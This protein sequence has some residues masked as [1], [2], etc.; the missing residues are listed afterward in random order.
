MTI[1]IIYNSP[2]M[3]QGDY[4][5]A[6]NTAYEC[7]KRK[8]KYVIKAKENS[9]FSLAFIKSMFKPCDGYSWDMLEEKNETEKVA[10][11]AT[12]KVAKSVKK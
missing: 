12:K 2:A 8:D 11:K 4:N 9:L 3:P 7:E 6:L 5:F 1:K 10:E